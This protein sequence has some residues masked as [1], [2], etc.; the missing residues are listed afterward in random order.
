MNNRYARQEI[1]PEVTKKGQEKLKNASVLCVGA[2]GLGSPALLYL[3]SAGIGKIGII[4]ADEVDES[5]LQRQV[6]YT[7]QDCSLKKVEQAKLAVINRNSQCKVQTYPYMLNAENALN[8]FKEYDVILDGSDNFET[9]FLINDA[10]LK[11]GKPWVYGAIQG[12]DG[13]VSVFNHHNS[14]CYRCLCPQKPKS[15]IKNCAENGVMG[16]LAGIIGTTQALQAIYIIL[17]SPTL[18]PL[19]GKLWILDT[20]SMKSQVVK[21]NKNTDCSS[22]NSNPKDIKLEFN[23][24]ICFGKKDIKISEINNQKNYIFIDIRDQEELSNGFIKNSIHIPLNQLEFHNF[25]KDTSKEKP[26]IVYCQHGMR[27]KIALEI[28]LK[29]GFKNTYNLEGGFQRYLQQNI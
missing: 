2:G 14:S 9:K 6:I 19:S 16:P 21:I 20:K 26:I 7:E 24:T 5:N 28:M 29:K 3:A 18:K 22:C 13:Q 23:Q 15:L 1:L 4:D 11:T 12:F 25:L 10:S 17:N 27:G 8:I